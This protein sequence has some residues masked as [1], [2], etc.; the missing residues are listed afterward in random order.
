MKD[1]QIRNLVKVALPL[2]IREWYERDGNGAGGMLHC[3][4]DDGNVD[5]ESIALDRERVRESGDS[6]AIAIVDAIASLP[7]DER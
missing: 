6:L 4:L 2:M 1:D 3:L 7:E 5:D